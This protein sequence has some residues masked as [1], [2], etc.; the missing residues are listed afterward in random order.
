[1]VLETK[2]A[3]KTYV[4]ATRCIFFVGSLSRKNL[5]LNVLGLEQSSDE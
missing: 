1:M 5:G 2:C 3:Q 4:I